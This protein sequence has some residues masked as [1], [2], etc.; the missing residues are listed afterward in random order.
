MTFSPLKAQFSLKQN[1]SLILIFHFTFSKLD[2]PN[3]DD[4]VLARL[5]ELIDYTES[6]NSIVE[7]NLLDPLCLTLISLIESKSG[8]NASL[9]LANMCKNMSVLCQRYLRDWHMERYYLEKSLF[10]L[11]TILPKDSAQLAEVLNLLGLYHY[12]HSE[13]Y[14]DLRTAEHYL[15]ESLNLHMLNI[16]NGPVYFQ[17]YN[18]LGLVYMKGR[19]YAKAKNCLANALVPHSDD[20]KILFNISMVYYYQSD[21]RNATRFVD[22][23]LQMLENSR[24]NI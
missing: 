10:L 12:N 13:T 20:L 1:I 19:S 6:V 5:S 16:E 17:V 22:K 3:N 4:T 2:F 7:R 18:N 24:S 15:N 8:S 23:A 14:G 11:R 9:L 21:I